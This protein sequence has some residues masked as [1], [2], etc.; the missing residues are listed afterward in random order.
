MPLITDQEIQAYFNEQSYDVRDRVTTYCTELKVGYLD[1]V[2]N[3]FLPSWVK[4]EA[5]RLFNG[6][7]STT[8]TLEKLNKVFPLFLHISKNDPKLVGYTAD[9]ASAMADRQFKAALGRVLSKHCAILSEN[10]VRTCV[11]AHDAD[12][13]LE[14]EYVT[15][16]DIINTLLSITSGPT[17]CMTTNYR[18]FTQHPYEVYE[19]DPRIKLAITRD[20]EGNITARSLVFHRSETD[21]VYIRT[22]GHPGLRRLLLR[23]GY[24]CGNFVGARLKKVAVNGGGEDTWLIPYLDA[25]G[26]HAASEGSQVVVFDDHLRVVPK[27][28]ASSMF[29]GES[30]L[31][32]GTLGRFTK[33]PSLIKT[34]LVKLAD[35]GEELD[36]LSGEHFEK[37]YHVVGETL[38]Q[39]YVRSKEG[40]VTAR[41]LGSPKCVRE[42]DTITLNTIKYVNTA[43]NLSHY[44]VHKLREKWYPDGG[45]VKGAIAVTHEGAVHY[46]R[47]VDAVHYVKADGTHDYIHKDML[48]RKSS[49]LLASKDAVK[50]WAHKNYKFL[51][52]AT[53]SKVCPT[54]HDVTQC[55]DGTWRYS[56]GARFQQFLGKDMAKGVGGGNPQDTV[57]G[58]Q[59][60]SELMSD[61]PT[62][63]AAY[64]S[65]AASLG[66]YVHTL[67]NLPYKIRR[68]Y[69]ANTL[70]T[71]YWEECLEVVPHVQWGRLDRDAATRLMMAARATIMGTITEVEAPHYLAQEVQQTQELELA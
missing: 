44:G 38:E 19:E 50:V 57:M 6:E 17:S 54:L 23:D 53:G 63:L 21:K 60:I 46:I 56:R 32:N 2:G 18:T 4:R 8:E 51:T 7:Y 22:Y 36:L 70:P 68:N 42:V 14:V 10:F 24:V 37:A 26:G 33:R 52:L 55:W 30:Y 59:R 28:L 25:N 41:Y 48:D 31:A 3:S 69:R 15:G 11:E 13:T 65:F 66:I 20:S 62:T 47:A 71:K 16:K 34:T 29:I 43:V 64:E 61:L 5:I 27:N 35:T 45:Y 40:Y 49:R 1:P 9:A 39:N 67:S 12:I 58:Q